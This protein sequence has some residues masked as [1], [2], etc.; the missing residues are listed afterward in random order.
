MKEKAAKIEKIRAA[1]EKVTKGD[2][3]KEKP[4]TTINIFNH[5]HKHPISEM[6]R[7]PVDKLKAMKNDFGLKPV[8]FEFPN[9]VMPD[10][11]APGFAS[12]NEKFKASVHYTGSGRGAQ[13]VE[14]QAQKAMDLVK[15]LLEFVGSPEVLRRLSQTER[16]YIS[17]PSFFGY[18]PTMEASGPEHAFV[19]SIK[20]QTQGRR[21][22]LAA[23]YDSVGAYAKDCGAE[24]KVWTLKDLTDLV[25]DS[26]EETFVLMK[27]KITFWKCTCGVGD[28]LFVPWGW[29][30]WEMTDNRSDVAGVRYAVLDDKS[31]PAFDFLTRLL[32]PSDPQAAVPANSTAAF[33]VKIHKVL[34][35]LDG[36]DKKSTGSDAEPSF[37][38]RAL[39]APAAKATAAAKVSATKT[40]PPTKKQRIK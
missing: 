32:L 11:L 28:A 29:A 35:L 20:I 26:T 22:V 7:F 19:A 8:V 24:G 10:P 9:L 23:P 13:A 36:A 18:S 4:K 14:A 40:E 16:E 1:K 3:A 12:F 33:L 25:S 21:T 5:L 6:H 15:P 39:T 30:I 27:E 38:K 17:K 37:G 2:A 31:S 34:E